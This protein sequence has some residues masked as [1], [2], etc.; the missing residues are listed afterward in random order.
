MAKLCG[1]QVFSGD[2]SVG[3]LSGR[4]VA[5]EVFL[6]LFHVCF[7]H[8]CAVALVY[9]AAF[10]DQPALSIQRMAQ[11]LRTRQSVIRS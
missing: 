4:E 2:G 6:A 8:G 7:G 9:S 5:S 1:R 3:T 11:A 10:A